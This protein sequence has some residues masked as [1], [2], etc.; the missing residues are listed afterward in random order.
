[1]LIIPDEKTWLALVTGAL[2]E[3]TYEYNF[4]QFGTATPEETAQRFIEMLGEYVDC[5]PTVSDLIIIQDQRS[6][7]TH[8]GTF[9]AGADRTRTLNTEVIDTGNHAA[10]SSNQITLQPGTYRLTAWASAWYVAGHRLKW[11]NVT[12]GTTILGSTEYIPQANQQTGNA[13]LSAV[14]TIT[15]AKVFELRHRCN[16]TADNAG[17]GFASSLG[18]EIYA[19]VKLERLAD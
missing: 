3:L 18:T 15:S 19:E 11:H 13:L 5:E 12:D 1:M 16:A 6:S 2:S 17:F 8:G 9:T 14:F 10:L 4:E 7:G